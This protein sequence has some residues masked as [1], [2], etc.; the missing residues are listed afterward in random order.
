MKHALPAL[1]A[2]GGGTILNTASTGGLMGWPELSAYVGSKHAVV[3]LTR[4]VALEYAGRGVCVNAL[5]PG[6]MD[7]RMIWAIGEAMAPGDPTNS[8]GRLEATVPVGR[9]GRPRG[10]RLVRRLAPA[11]LPRVPDRRRPA[12]RRRPDRGL[13]R[14]NGRPG[15]SL[16]HL[17]KEERMEL[18][19]QDIPGPKRDFVG[20]GGASRRSSGPTAPRRR[21]PRRQLRGGLGVLDARG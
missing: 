9:L 7:T 11:R 18:I 16:R 8:G 10:G 2:G 13:S 19:D 3:G 14:A 15:L 1:L 4:A 20:Y 21:Q 12:D 6:P 5:C 17:P